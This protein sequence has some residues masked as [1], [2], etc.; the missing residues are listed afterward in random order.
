MT[1]YMKR[2]LSVLI[3]WAKSREKNLKIIA[4]IGYTLM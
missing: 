1:K 3:S 4:M 2:G